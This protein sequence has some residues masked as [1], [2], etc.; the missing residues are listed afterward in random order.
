MHKIE[1]NNDTKYYLYRHLR[2]DSGIPFYIG[3]GVKRKLHSAT[4]ESEYERAHYTNNRSSYW[5]N[6]HYKCGTIVEILYECN[7]RLDIIN[8]EIEFINLYGRKDNKTGVLCN[9]TDGGELIGKFPPEI[10]EIRRIKISRA[11]KDRVR[12][13]STFD[14]ISESKKK[15]IFKCDLNMNII[16]KYNSISDAAESIKLSLSSISKCIKNNN[17]TAGSYKWKLETTTN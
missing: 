2:K 10:E 12:K 11:L 6:I 7:N 15:P 3:I 9:L 16:C 8:K 13:Q 14:K 5:N 17:Y 1:R 4:F